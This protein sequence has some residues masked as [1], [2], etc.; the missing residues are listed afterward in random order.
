MQ[1]V[2]SVSGT[3]KFRTV[4][5]GRGGSCVRSCHPGFLLS[6]RLYL[7]LVLGNVN[8]TLLSKQAKYVVVVVKGWVPVGMVVNGAT[9]HPHPPRVACSL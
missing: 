4:N 6:L 1:C 5:Q 8:V 2:W 7:S 3:P 9:P